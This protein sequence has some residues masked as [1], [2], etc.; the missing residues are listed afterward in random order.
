MD[1]VK[2]STHVGGFGRGPVRLVEEEGR[3]R[4]QIMHIHKATLLKALALV[5]TSEGTRDA[6][7]G[8]E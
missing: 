8:R 5:T 1:V 2:L 3:E 6:L 4:G 7:E